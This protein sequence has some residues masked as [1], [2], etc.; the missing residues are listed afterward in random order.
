MN[1]INVIGM[2]FGMHGLGLE[3]RDK[4]RAMRMAGIEVCI[5]NE[6]YSSLKN[7]V[8]DT[9]IEKLIVDQ[10]KY[11]TNLICHNLPATG[12]IARKN[13]KLLEG[14]YNIGAPYWEFPQL[15][16]THIH[17][18]DQLDE[19]WV[20]TDFL[21]ECFS[22]YT[23]VP[24]NKM[25]LHMAPMIQ[26][27]SRI[28]HKGNN[29]PLVFGYVFDYNSMSARKDPLLL[30]TA[31]LECF[32]DKPKINVKLIIKY[33]VERS[34]LV[35]QRDVDDL[36]FMATLDS[37]IEL[38]SEALSAEGMDDLYDSFDVYIS[39]HRAEG[40]GR[41]IIESMLRGKAVAATG[42]SGPAEYLHNN[43]AHSLEYYNTHVGSAAI[44]DIK[45]HFSWA[46]VK[47]ESVIDAL[48]IFASDIGIVSK[49]GENAKQL[50][51]KHHGPVA[52]GVACKERLEEI[53]HD[54]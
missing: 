38:V 32:A 48:N 15:P 52:H 47:L 24:I 37:R 46:E 2:P 16:E 45:S 41:G 4:V 42:Y 40:L 27:S 54:R 34:H 29:K 6:N 9:E 21:K 28:L 7:Q 20:S 1:G 8:H 31:F 10:P 25:P 36:T 18:L 53:K 35:R 17:G 19:V 44:G 11:D 12:L 13:P 49:Y 30:I 33:K 23:G 14:R 3:L 39:P 43:C 5:L 26:K 50:L 51:T 22:P